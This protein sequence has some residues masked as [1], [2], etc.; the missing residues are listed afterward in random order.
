MSAHFDWQQ[1]YMS[2]KAQR[3]TS[4]TSKEVKRLLNGYSQMYPKLTQLWE[5]Y[6]ISQN[7][8]ATLSRSSREYGEFISRIAANSSNG[9]EQK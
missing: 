9:R 5:S 6:R 3:A 4:I 7:L 8:M 1:F 2:V